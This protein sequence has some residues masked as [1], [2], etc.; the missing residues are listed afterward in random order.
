MMIG[1]DTVIRSPVIWHPA[2][3]NIFWHWVPMFTHAH[4]TVMHSILSQ[5]GGPSEPGMRAEEIARRL[6]PDQRI[7]VGNGIYIDGTCGHRWTWS[8]DL[9]KLKRTTPVSRP[10]RKAATEFQNLTSQPNAWIDFPTTRERTAPIGERVSTGLWK[11]RQHRRRGKTLLASAKQM[12]WS[13]TEAH[14]M[15]TNP[16]RAPGRPPC[17]RRFQAMV[18]GH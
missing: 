2:S 8:M 6:P 7:P 18:S 14:L 1:G 5:R 4:P 12:R 9:T 16:R 3:L 17:A 15:L 13:K 11:A 10:L